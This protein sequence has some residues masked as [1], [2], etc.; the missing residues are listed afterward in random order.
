MYSKSS[1]CKHDMPG[2]IAGPLQGATGHCCTIHVTITHASEHLEA[3]Q[4]Q[5]KDTRQ[6]A[7]HVVDPVPHGIAAAALARLRHLLVL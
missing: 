4:V 5:Q 7:Q 1:S 3:L 2:R 6:A